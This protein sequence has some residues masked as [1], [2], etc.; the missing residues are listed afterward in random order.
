METLK[1][2]TST[3]VVAP[4][5]LRPD[6]PRDLETI[7][8]K[9]LEK[10]PLKRY[11]SARGP[12]GGLAA[13]P[14]GS[15]DRGPARGARGAIRPLEPTQPVDRPFIRDDRRD[16]DRRHRRERHPDDLGETCGVGRPIGGPNRK[17]GT[18]L[19][20]SS[21]RR[22]PGRSMNSSTKSSS[23][24]P[25]RTIRPLSTSR[26]IPISRSGRS[27]TA[28]RANPGEVRR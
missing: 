18:A 22:P 19:G 27:W 26:P 10:E 2:V 25:A 7:C 14:R 16:P 8:L 11:A 5:L 21:R 4:H 12:G 15:S 6:V 23:P 9:C 20:P 24:R 17:D 1:L 3:E 13:V 28:P